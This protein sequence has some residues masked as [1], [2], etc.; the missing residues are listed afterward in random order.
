MNQSHSYLDA[1]IGGGRVKKVLKLEGNSW[2]AHSIDDTSFPHEDYE[3]VTSEKEI[4]I[5]GGNNADG[6][7]QKTVFKTGDGKTWKKLP[8]EMKKTENIYACITTNDKTG[9]DNLVTLN[10]GTG[11]EIYDL[12][13]ANPTTDNLV[14]VKFSLEEQSWP[15]NMSSLTCHDGW[16]YVILLIDYKHRNYIAHYAFSVQLSK[17]DPNKGLT[18]FMTSGGI[19][20]KY[21]DR[22][23]PI[24][25]KNKFGVAGGNGAGKKKFYYVNTSDGQWKDGGEFHLYQKI[26]TDDDKYLVPVVTK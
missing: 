6:N 1:N 18:Q 9:N 20:R 25:Y 5:L 19:S 4:Y 26:D 17:I 3:I 24:V 15:H 2:T 12:G 13:S 7:P 21:W 11:M 16:I 22:F 8:W 14:T 23:Q 10:E